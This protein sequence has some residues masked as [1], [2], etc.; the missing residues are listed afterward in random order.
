MIKFIDLRGQDATGRFAF[1]DRITDRF[2]VISDVS[3]WNTFDDLE[4]DFNSDESVFDEFILD[5]YRALCP[6]WAFQEP[7]PLIMNISDNI[8]I[9]ELRKR[10]YIVITT[11]DVNDIKDTMESWK[12]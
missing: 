10:G 4:Y 8:M 7:E 9:D 3:A 2:D 1:F 5:R 11:G 12:P 6:D